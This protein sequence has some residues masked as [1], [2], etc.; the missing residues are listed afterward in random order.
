MPVHRVFGR[1]AGKGYPA[2]DLLN[3]EVADRL[4]GSV[5]TTRTASHGSA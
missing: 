3:K 2:K 4:F 5:S 1:R